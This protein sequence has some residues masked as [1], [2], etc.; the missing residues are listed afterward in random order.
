MNQSQNDLLERPKGKGIKRHL[1]DHPFYFGHYLNM[2]LHNAFKVIVH[3]SEKHQLKSEG[4]EEGRLN[5]SPLLNIQPKS[6]IE[7]SAILKDLMRHFTFLSH[8]EVRGLDNKPIELNLSDVQQNLRDAFYVLNQL[9][10]NYVHFNNVKPI[11]ELKE[12]KGKR[13][14]MLDVYKSAYQRLATRYNHEERGFKEADINHLSLETGKHLPPDILQ[15]QATDAYYDKSLAYFTCL[16]LEPAHAS[17]FLSRLHGFHN[18]TTPQYRATRA[19]YMMYSCRLPERKLESSDIVLDMLNELGRYPKSLFAVWSEDDKKKETKIETINSDDNEEER[20]SQVKRH[21]DRFPYFALRYFDDAKVQD[22]RFLGNLFFQIQLGKYLKRPVYEKSMYGDLQDRYLTA[23]VYTFGN[24]SHYRN[25]YEAVNQDVIHE[26]R[27]LKPELFPKQWLN[28]EGSMLRE[29]ITQFSPQYNFGEQNIGFKIYETAKYNLLPPFI[30]T[31]T[32][33]PKGVKVKQE[34]PTAFISTYELQNVFLYQYLHHIGFIEK[35]VSTYI[36]EFVKK[37][38]QVFKDV[39]SGAFSP[40]SNYEFPRY[41]KHIKSPTKRKDEKYADFQIKLQQFEQKQTKNT[42]LI[43]H[44]RKELSKEIES[45]YGIKRTALPD[46]IMEYLLGYR[47]PQYKQL[48][49]DKL[50]KQLEDVEKRLKKM[51]EA[52]QTRHNFKKQKED[53]EKVKHYPNLGEIASYIA[54]DIVFLMPHHD[55]IANG[56]T[57]KQ[58]INSDEF[59]NLQYALAMF[60]SEKEN[61][62]KNF[63]ELKLV[64]RES[65]IKHPFLNFISIDGCH[66]IVD[67]YIEYLK[68]KEGFI[69]SVKDFVKNNTETDVKTKYGYILPIKIKKATEKA[70]F[71]KQGSTEIPLPIFLPRGLFR[72]SIV[73]ALKTHKPELNIQE[74]DNIVRCLSRFLDNDKQPFYNLKRYIKPYEKAT[75]TEGVSVEFQT[76]LTDLTFQIEQAQHELQKATDFRHHEAMI[77]GKTSEAATEAKEDE[78]DIKYHIQDLQKEVDKI[79]DYE[80]T[81]RYTES[82]D[83]AQWLMVLDLLKTQHPELSNLMGKK[84]ED[85]ESVLESFTEAKEKIYNIKVVDNSLKIKNYGKLR[86]MLKDRRLEGLTKYFAENE[87]VPFEKLKAELECYDKRREAF[88]DLIY[89]FEKAVS[90]HDVLKT[91]LPT[92]STDGK[93]NHQSFMANFGIQKLN[94]ENR[95]YYDHEVYVTIASEML[96]DETLKMK[97]KTDILKLRN[98]IF[99]N[100]YPAQYYQKDEDKFYLTWLKSEVENLD[101]TALVT[102]RIFDIATN[103]YQSLLD[104]CKVVVDVLVGG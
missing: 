44:R 16:F 35:D 49:K 104:K 103:Y 41:E 51:G 93:Y 2:A 24:L 63:Q 101:N 86:S 43:E 59:R 61:I 83:R 56:K 34:V 60:G 62:K 66:G 31:P 85:I 75:N 20:Y 50:D 18:T 26:K 25:L 17:V 82:N 46:S 36:H 98:K 38:H 79:K 45:K 80:K 15:A 7:K 55:H 70:F 10:N 12:S 52:K 91:K 5:T 23:P 100:E 6:P 73:N 11:E 81:I 1:K 84:L 29:E 28:T 65:P 72:E 67:F 8:L 96:D 33:T 95:D 69:K 21:K 57:V 102:D 42:A 78:K 99:H 3:L 88:S 97:Y 48:A 77:Y 90:E 76:R 58:K 32:P 74:R 89:D 54:E 19:C 4:I 92:F 47:T 9:R 27:V 68:E 87:E 94:N 39:K 40:K 71:I 64:Q 22:K 37:I 30:P 13:L 14:L 53:T